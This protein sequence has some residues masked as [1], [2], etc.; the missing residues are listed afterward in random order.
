MLT[1]LTA[2]PTVVTLQLE[3][4]PPPPLLWSFLGFLFIPSGWT[5]ESSKH[6][7]TLRAKNETGRR[8]DREGEAGAG[9][10]VWHREWERNSREEEEDRS[11]CVHFTSYSVFL[12]DSSLTAS[13]EASRKRNKEIEKFNL[14][15]ISSH[16]ISEPH[17]SKAFSQT[18]LLIDAL[19]KFTVVLGCTM[20]VSMKLFRPCYLILQRCIPASLKRC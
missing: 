12:R 15:R 7:A 1:R 20:S 4:P 18:I 2:C 3:D 17:A 8:E 14:A 5:Q 19:N 6:H 16:H 10:F 11:P 13:E 9:L